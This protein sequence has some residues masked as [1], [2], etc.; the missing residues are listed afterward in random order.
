MNTW[1]KFPKTLSLMTEFTYWKMAE[2]YLIDTT[3]PEG[4]KASVRGIFEKGVTV[5]RSPQ[6]IGNTNVRNNRIDKSVRVTLSE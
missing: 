1:I 3:I 6:R 5:W 2:C 4:F